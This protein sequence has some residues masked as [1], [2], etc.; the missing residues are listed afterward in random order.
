MVDSR[1]DN[2]DV[3][4]FFPVHQ[5][6]EKRHL[7]IE[8]LEVTNA[9]LKKNI[10]CLYKTAKLELQRRDKKISQLQ[11]QIRDLELM[12]ASQQKQN[13]LLRGC[14]FLASPF[15]EHYYYYH[16][17]QQLCSGSMPVSRQSG[18]TESK[19][20]RSRSPHRKSSTKE[21]RTKSHHSNRD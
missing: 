19:R 6:S 10:S 5:E 13:L 11:E 21:H 12:V 14:H 18:S 9:A 16:Q 8:K 3:D 17:Q 7:S 20:S 2:G 1:E 15:P 4:P